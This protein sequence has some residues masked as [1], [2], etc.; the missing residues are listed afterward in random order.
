MATTP[1]HTR[2]NRSHAG[3]SVEEI[4]NEPDW[5][6]THKYRIGFRDRNDRH[7]GYTHAGDDTIT[8]E[9]QDFLAQAREEAEELEGELGKKELINVREFMTKQEASIQYTS[10]VYLKRLRASFD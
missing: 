9:M 2:P 6:T 4:R 5:T 1:H 10:F 7:T 3:S 8:S